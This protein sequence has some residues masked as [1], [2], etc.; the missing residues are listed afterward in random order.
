[1]FSIFELYEYATRVRRSFALKLASLSWDEVV[2]NKEASFYSMKNILLHMIDV[3]DYI[4]NYVIPG[5]SQEYKRRKWEEYKSFDDIFAH[6]SEVEE[7]TRKFLSTMDENKLKS[8]VK[9]SLQS[10][11]SFELSIEEWL[12]QSFTEQLYH[13]GELIALLWQMNIEPPKM[14]WYYNNPRRKD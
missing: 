12:F 13:M 6:L 2:K 8:M 14:Q 10:G 3:E 5:R 11:E 7:K 1:M 4:V 9:L